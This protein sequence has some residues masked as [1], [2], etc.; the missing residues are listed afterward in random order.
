MRRILALALAA[1]IIA[2]VAVVLATRGTGSAAA[3]PTN[4]L[5]G[6][7]AASAD[8]RALVE[9]LDR[10]GL[11]LLSLEAKS[12]GGNVVISPLSIHDVLSMILN[13]AQG[14]TETEM[15]QAL[16]L[17]T[18][19]VASV[20]QGWADLIAAAQAGKTPAVQIAN[21]LWLK[22]GVPFDPAFLDANRNF[23]AAA[24]RALPG[25]PDKAAAAINDWVDQR[26][27]G[28]IKKIVDPSYF[29]DQTILALV[30]TV[31]LKTA[32]RETFDKGQTAPAPFT[33]ADGSTVQV[34]MMNQSLTAPVSQTA[35]YDAVA[36]QTKGPVTVWV[37]VPKGTATPETVA[38]D[39]A[40]AQPQNAGKTMPPIGK[41]LP[42]SP[43]LA[44][45]YKAAKPQSVML[46][47]PRFK[48]TFS[49]PSLN[50]DL[51]A[52]GM[53]RAFSP[54]DAELMGIVK[55]GTT[56]NVYIQRVVHKAVLDVNEGGIEAAAATAAIVGLTSGAVAPLT[57]R[58][59]R[60]FFMVITEKATNAPLF[61]A[62]I[63]DPRS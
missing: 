30:N 29:N 7:T 47:L 37:V 46:A 19:P 35:T 52:M 16:A 49:A 1:I 43:G 15:R 54:A 6:N 21:S 51:S 2:A 41:P 3:E 42:A 56:G 45:M 20:N 57:I 39:F 60:P 8:A 63:R 13:G 62:I 22:D 53:P 61:M 34:P 9:P 18:L 12:T 50:A 38:A 4:P 11:G 31:H 23:F 44:S 27:A 55:P 40:A 10:F 17:G 24:S 25:N 26:T 33:L 32:W 14:Q 48:T 5:R 59:D 36:L 58:A 28:L